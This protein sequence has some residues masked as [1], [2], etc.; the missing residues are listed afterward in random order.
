MTKSEIVT[1]K[2]VYAIVQ[3]LEDQTNKM[4]ERHD[5]RI[6]QNEK[7]IANQ[8]GWNRAESLFIS[9]VISI[10]GIFIGNRNV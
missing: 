9:I 7:D 3:R 1:L 6:L 5:E 2:D 4:M 8:R 10:I